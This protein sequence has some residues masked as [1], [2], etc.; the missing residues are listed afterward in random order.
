[1]VRAKVPL[2]EAERQ[3]RRSLQLDAFLQAAGNSLCAVLLA[4]RDLAARREPR[5]PN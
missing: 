5:P 3:G 4:E 1:M 2:S